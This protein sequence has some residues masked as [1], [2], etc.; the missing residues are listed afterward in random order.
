MSDNL[1]LDLT[2]R[3][4]EIIRQALRSQQESH[5][6]NDFKILERETATLSSRIN[7]ALIEMRKGLA[8]V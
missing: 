2:P 4:V 6:R 7:D 8:R 5:K 3:E 1:L